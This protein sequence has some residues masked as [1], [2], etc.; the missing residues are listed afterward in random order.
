[1][2]IGEGTT[3]NYKPH[4]QVGSG[5]SPPVIIVNNLKSKE[6]SE[7]QTIRIISGKFTGNGNF[8]GYNAA[9]NRIH[10]P[11]RLME[12]IGL[13]VDSKIQF[14]LYA[15]VVER[16]FSSV[17]VNGQPTGEKFKRSQAGS[18][19]LDQQ[20]MIDAVNGDKLLSLEA[21][22]QLVSTAKSKGLSQKSI[23]ALLN[24]VI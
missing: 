22:E 23:D 16:E 19:F 9:G 15:L 11:A 1:M 5:D 4:L 17:D 12:T 8:S 24:A 6:M 10:V 21:E 2:C 18:I 13:S 7:M 14:P 20:S 3:P